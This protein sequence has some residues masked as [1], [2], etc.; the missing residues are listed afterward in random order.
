VSDD[1]LQAEST[2]PLTRRRWVDVLLGSSFVAWVGAVVYPVLRYLTPLRDAGGSGKMT[3]TDEQKKELSGNGF[4]I[5]RL[6]TD[7]VLLVKEQDKKVRALSA[8]CTHEGCTVQYVPADGV[9]WCAC[10]NGKFALDGRVISG[11]PPRPLAAY[12]VDGDLSGAVSVTKPAGV[13]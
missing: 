4:L 11:P 1:L 3:L 13:A 2:P 8:K 9:V 7:R 12:Q 10:H 5:A 6:G